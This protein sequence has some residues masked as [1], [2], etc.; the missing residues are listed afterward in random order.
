MYEIES[1]WRFGIEGS[2]TGKQYRYDYTKTP[3]YF[4]AA[5]MLQRNFSKHLILVLNIENIFDY[6]MSRI[7]SLYTGSISNPTFKP[8]WAPIDGRVANISLR[9]KL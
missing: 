6:R 9:W 2:L 4:F 1:K 3:A 7:E 8:L 5:A